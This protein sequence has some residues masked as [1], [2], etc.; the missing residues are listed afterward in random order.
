MQIRIRAASMATCIRACDPP[1]TRRRPATPARRPPAW[2]VFGYTYA[3]I[4]ECESP[5]LQPHDAVR[6][7][8]L[9][10]ARAS[11]RGRRVPPPPPRSDRLVP[12]VQPGARHHV[13]RRGTY[14]GTHFDTALR[15]Q[16]RIWPH[17]RLH[18]DSSA[19][20]FGRACDR[21]RMPNAYQ[22]A[23]GHSDTHTTAVRE[24]ISPCAHL[25]LRGR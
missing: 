3:H 1:G 19:R 10:A 8:R 17:T 25:Q 9:P 12:A 15:T 5:Y 16:M 4:R 23:R 7:R 20:I 2:R 13:L 6:V 14:S 18:I 22:Q 21:I 24:C 11:T